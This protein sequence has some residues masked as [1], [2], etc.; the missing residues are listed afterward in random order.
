MP[1]IQSLEGSLKRE[2]ERS[3]EKPFLI[4][5]LKSLKIAV[6][7]TKQTTEAVSN[8]IKIDPSAGRDRRPKSPAAAVA[9]HC[10]Q[11]LRAG[12]AC[13]RLQVYKM[14]LGR[15]PSEAPCPPFGAFSFWLHF[16][17][18]LLTFACRLRTSMRRMFTT[19]IEIPEVSR[20]RVDDRMW[21]FP[22]SHDVTA[23]ILG[24]RGDGMAG[25]WTHGDERTGSSA[26]PILRQPEYSPV[27][28]P[29]PSRPAAYNFRIPA[30]S[31]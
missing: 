4:D 17:A 7:P 9:K 28:T 25:T 12:V 27:E 29:A 2:P 18:S 14:G 16:P 20:S 13:G 8:R 26:L 22:R 21:L 31:M 11:V 15:I 6:S 10:V 5:R 1:F 19:P 3:G 23:A 30:L 24:V